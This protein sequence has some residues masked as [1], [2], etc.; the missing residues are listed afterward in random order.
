VTLKLYGG[1][2]REFFGCLKLSPTLETF[3]LRSKDRGTLLHDRNLSLV[4]SAVGRVL[5]SGDLVELAKI[6]G[7][8]EPPLVEKKLHVHI[9]NSCIELDFEN[10]CFSSVGLV[11]C[12][13]KYNRYYG[14]G[15]DEPIEVKNRMSSSGVQLLCS[16]LLSISVK[17]VNLS[18]HKVGEKGAMY[19]KRALCGT[20]TLQELIIRD[21]DL[22]EDGIALIFTGLTNNQSL[23]VLDAAFNNIGSYGAVR[24]SRFINQ[25]VLE[26]LDIS[27]CGI[28]EEGMVAVASA[29]RTNAT[30]RKLCLYSRGSVISQRSELEL[31]RML[32][33]NRNLSVVQ[34]NQRLLE[35]PALFYSAEPIRCF[36]LSQETADILLDEMGPGEFY[37]AVRMSPIVR[38]V[39]V[40]SSSS[41]GQILMSGHMEV[42]G[43]ILQVQ[44]PPTAKGQ[45]DLLIPSEEKVWTVDYGRMLVQ[46]SSI[47]HWTFTR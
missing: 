46:P 22:G 11:E 25:T 27:S 12:Q 42:A 44:K 5:L 33:Q 9:F 16:S 29:L 36:R 40:D 34:V 1:E 2:D 3:G 4:D 24:L 21:C 18:A 20:K 41:L 6:F 28:G 14:S 43:N 7:L 13:H 38:S 31:S 30:L 37:S 23:K 47:S 10:G 15:E 8:N 39:A 35:C 32:L 17:E 45:I 19:L 26:V